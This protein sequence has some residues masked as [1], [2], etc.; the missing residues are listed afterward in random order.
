MTAV[1]RSSKFLDFK[2][3]FNVEKKYVN[4]YFRKTEARYWQL[5]H[6]L[7][8]RLKKDE[9]ISPWNTVYSD[10]RQ[11]LL[12]IFKDYSKRV[13]NCVSSFCKELYY[14]CDTFEGTTVRMSCEKYYEEFYQ[15]N[16]DRQIA[17]RIRQLD[18]TIFLERKFSEHL[19]NSS[20]KRSMV[21]DEDDEDSSG[22]KRTRHHEEQTV[23]D[24]VCTQIHIVFTVKHT[25]TNIYFF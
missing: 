18:S 2:F 16:L 3:N 12:F 21:D 14:L 7:N 20:N 13:P 10:W 15:A 5:K 4:G 23:H 8:F 25:S 19:R 22:S 6:Y 1:L 17:E 24:L 9:R 11:S